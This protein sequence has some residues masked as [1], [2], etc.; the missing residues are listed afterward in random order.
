MIKRIVT[1]SLCLISV[2]LTFA[3]DMEITGEATYYDDGKLSRVECM[4]RALEM[5]RINA[6]STE[7]GTL[8]TQDIKQTDRIDKRGERTDLLAESTT[9]VRGEW[10]AD[11]GEPKYEISY[12]KDQNLI[13][14]CKVK[15]VARPLSNEAAAFEAIVLRNGNSTINQATDF[16]SGDRMGLSFT[17]SS[18]GYVMVFFED[19]SGSV[20]NIL[21]YSLNGSR[22]VKVK[23]QKE[24]IFFR[25]D[26]DYPE[27]GTPEEMLLT[28]DVYPEFNKMYVLFSPNPFSAPV[29]KDK[30]GFP[31]MDISDFSK[32]LI[33]SRGADPK[34]GQKVFLLTVNPR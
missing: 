30:E 29:M 5:A 10:I 20:Y 28:A 21:P 7:F 16:V 23:R 19:E 31:A 8:L 32:W 9:T 12:D 1:V 22:D 33:R 11:V 3:K 18:D 17:G 26:V 2:F 6:L 34:M 13:V 15:I 14:S 4:K 25:R 27:F 24:Y